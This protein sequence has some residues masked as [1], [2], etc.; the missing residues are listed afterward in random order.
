MFGIRLPLPLTCQ[1][2]MLYLLQGAQQWLLLMQRAGSKVLKKRNSGI[3]ISFW[4]MIWKERNKRVFDHSECS[5]PRLSM[6]IEEYIHHLQFA[7][8]APD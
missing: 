1:I 3:I 6:L 2:F 5:V 7:L 4:W 8:Q